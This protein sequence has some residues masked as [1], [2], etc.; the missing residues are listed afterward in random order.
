MLRLTKKLLFGIEAVLDVAY[1]AKSRPVQA[2]A[3]TKRQGIP[4]RYLEQV[5]QALVR[6]GVLTGQRGPKGGYRLAR[7]P[8]SITIAE[9]VNIV[10]TIEVAPDPLTG[11]PASALGHRIVRPIWMDLQTELLERLGKT[12]LAELVARAR[13]AGV[14]SE[15]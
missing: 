9:I 15:T 4:K 5:L 10:R 3:I 11:A 12:T 14:E 7:E 8:E 13:E 6:A 2:S 1:N